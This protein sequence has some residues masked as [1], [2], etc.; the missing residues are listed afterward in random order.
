MKKVARML[1]SQRSLILNYF[2]AKEQIALSA[3]EGL[4]ERRK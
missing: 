2:R 1:R 3:V 4:N